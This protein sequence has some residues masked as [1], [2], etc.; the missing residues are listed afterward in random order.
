[1]PY[2]IIASKFNGSSIASGRAGVPRQRIINGVPTDANSSGLALNTM[3]T[4]LTKNNY[5]PNDSFEEQT[6]SDIAILCL[7]AISVTTETIDP[8]APV[9]TFLSSKRVP[10]N[11][12]DKKNEMQKKDYGHDAFPNEADPFYEMDQAPADHVKETNKKAKNR[13]KTDEA[14]IEL[15]T[16]IS[17]INTTQL[18]SNLRLKQLVE[19]R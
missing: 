6:Y 4:L 5:M 8:T 16:K 12:A 13:V 19:G 10:Q 14:L 2:Q 1:M 15:V 11:N 18:R 17:I 9:K 3:I 7:G